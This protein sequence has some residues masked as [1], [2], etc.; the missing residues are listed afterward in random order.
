MDWHGLVISDDELE[1][2][3]EALKRANPHIAPDAIRE[4]VLSADEAETGERCRDYARE[5]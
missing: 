2:R 5:G 1:E 4:M 3:I